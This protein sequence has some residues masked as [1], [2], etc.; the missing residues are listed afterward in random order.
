M[1]KS[2][3][4]GKVQTVLGLIQ[5]EELGITHTHEHILC[6]VTA[7]L[8]TTFGEPEDKFER[9]MIQHPVT[10]DILW[11]LRYNPF[12]NWDDCQ[13]LDEQ[14]A[15]D[16]LIKFQRLGGNSIIDV[17]IR[18]LNH[19]PLAL[20]Q[21]SSAV[22]INIII[23]TGYY[24]EPSYPPEIDINKKSEEEIAGEF[25]ADVMEGIRDSGVRAGIIGEL[26]CSWPLTNNEKKVLRAGALAQKCT[27]AALTVHPGRDDRA[28]IEII[29]ILKNAGADLERT[30]MCHIDRS[31]RNIN[32]RL[33]IAETGCYLEY[34]V[35]GREG[36]YPQ[37]FQ[38]LDLPNDAQRIDEL[39]DLVEKGFQDKLLLSQDICNKTALCRYGGW[40]YGHLLRDTVP[41]MKRKGLSSELIDKMLIENPKK[42]LP[43]Q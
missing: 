7:W 27:G 28:P 42:L 32:T 41:V 16:E 6:D 26:G 9:E 36:Y 39:M 18:G 40:G 1:N 37:K 17:S 35:F 31:V 5:P 4:R 11:W 14:T 25:I 15:I 2:E 33:E 34:D 30:I 21:I 23:G 38:A 29:Q 3:L 20:C 24:V 8:K 19:R 10:M 12:Q 22:G 13:L 43:F